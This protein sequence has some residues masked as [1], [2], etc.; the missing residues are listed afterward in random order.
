MYPTFN[1]HDFTKIIELL[2]KMTSC[3]LKIVSLIVCTHF[4]QCPSCKMSIQ[5]RAI[6]FSES[7]K[8]SSL[9]QKK[10]KSRCLYTSGKKNSSI[11][12]S[13]AI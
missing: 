5:K 3:M 4:R 13:A 10:G 9:L 2:Q 8:H 12:K 6:P 7:V 1:N 11:L